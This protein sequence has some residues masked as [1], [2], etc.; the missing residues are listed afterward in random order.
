MFFN[1]EPLELP[2]NGSYMVVSLGPA[3]NFT[4]KVLDS[5]EFGSV[6]M[7]ACLVHNNITET[8][9]VCTGFWVIHSKTKSLGPVLLQ[10]EAAWLSGRNRVARMLDSQSHDPGFSLSPTLPS[11]CIHCSWSAKVQILS[12]MLVNCQLVASCQ[13]E[14][15][16]LSSM[17]YMIICYMARNFFPAVHALIGYYEVTWHLTMKLFPAIIS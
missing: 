8:F 15:L 4:G 12:S 3:N 9:L 1:W 10:R 5:L 2:E 17:L 16:I 7:L 6:L 14:F 13:L 11:N